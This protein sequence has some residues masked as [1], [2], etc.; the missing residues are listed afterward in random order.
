MSA[1]AAVVVPLLLTAVTM[2]AVVRAL[3]RAADEA[4]QLRL[5][6]LK[7]SAV[8][9]EVVELAEGVRQLRSGVDR[10]AR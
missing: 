7:V 3:G 9:P 5:A 2:V 10:L 8:R 1:M 4:D 6:L